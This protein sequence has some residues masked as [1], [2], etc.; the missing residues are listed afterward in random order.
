V[1]SNFRY[2]GTKAIRALRGLLN[3]TTLVKP[4]NGEV[5]R[6]LATRRTSPRASGATPDYPGRLWSL[7]DTP[8]GRALFQGQWCAVVDDVPADLNIVRYWDLAATEEAEFNDPGLDG[9][10]QAR[11]RQERRL[12]AL[13]MVRRRANPG[14]V[15]RLLLDTATQDSTREDG[16]SG[17]FRQAPMR[18][19][20][21]PNA[22]GRRTGYRKCR[23]T[24]SNSIPLPE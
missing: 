23:R 18:G 22:T 4:M 19:S 5:I 15:E 11:P 20:S 8:L 13:G 17:E 16:T 12:L 2:R 7:E 6:G 14:D 24:R 10:H 21:R 1:D 9:R 3:D